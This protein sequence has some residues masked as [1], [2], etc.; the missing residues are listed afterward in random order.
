MSKKLIQPQETSPVPH[1]FDARPGGLV[2]P[3]TV[4]RDTE[5]WSQGDADFLQKMLRW[6]AAKRLKLLFYCLAPSCV[7]RLKD[8]DAT[9]VTSTVTDHG[10]VLRCGHLDR[11][12]FETSP[13]IVHKIA[14]ADLRRRQQADR[15]LRL[16]RA[17]ADRHAKGAVVDTA[18]IDPLPSTLDLSNSSDSPSK[19]E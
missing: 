8:G 1:G 2:V 11:R 16:A 19:P 13:T 3:E 17:R 15:R 18:A 6:A 14:A 9:P 12:L 5:A 7:D 4:V 10:R